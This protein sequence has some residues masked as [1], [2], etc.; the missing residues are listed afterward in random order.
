MSVASTS[1]A[2]LIALINV[3]IG[4]DAPYL[5]E[6]VNLKV[7][8][9]QCHCI[10]GATGS[11]KSSLLQLLA[12]NFEHTYQGEVN[13][14]P[15]CV[16]ALVC[17]DPN[18]QVIRQTIGAEVAFALENLAVPLPQM[19]QQ[20]QH[21][22]QLVGL[23]L[24]LDTAIAHLSLGQKYR[25][26]IAAQLVCNPTVLLLDEPWAQLDDAGVL[27]LLALLTD[28]LKQGIA[29]VIVE[30]NSQAFA[31]LISHAWHIHQCDLVAGYHQQQQQSIAVVTSYDEQ[32][33]PVY[34]DIEA[35]EF[36]FEQDKLFASLQ[37]LTLQAGQIIALV[38]SN[39]CGKT[40]LLKLL[41]GF[42][43]QVKSLPISVLQQQP[44]LG[45]YGANLGFLMQRPSRQLFETTVI[46]ELEFSLSRFNL[47][48]HNA[49]NML[50]ELDLMHLRDLSPHTLSYG[51]Q[52]L[53]ALACLACMNPK[54]LLL[55]DPFAGLDNYYA[56]KVAQLI[57]MLA[58]QGCGLIISSHRDE[59]MVK[60]DTVWRIN[61]RLLVAETSPNKV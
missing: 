44:K 21:A 56:A 37:P 5:L 46:K 23:N 55:D 49:D 27:E 14:A 43:P 8:K 45:S 18:V 6:G 10:T 1:L 7:E 19:Q 61:Q 4:Y 54:V 20:V 15:H 58:Q 11:G 31:S 9:G 28:L 30:H 59:Q 26:M 33:S 48:L 53:I 13:F 51:Q 36:G 34:I 39:G 47:P 35:F 42:N 17:Q 57:Q 22:L 2:P 12:G 38:G 25:L 29:I 32:N 60:A 24:A 41:A 52:H 16:T 3:D 50:A 40:S